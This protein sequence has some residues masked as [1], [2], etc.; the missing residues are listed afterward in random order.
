MNNNDLLACIKRWHDCAPR[1]KSDREAMIQIE[2]I[3]AALAAREPVTAERAEMLM[4]Y[5]DL[6]QEGRDKAKKY[7][8]DWI[9]KGWLEIANKIR[10]LILGGRG[11]AVTGDW[12]PSPDNINALPDPLKKY[13]HDL[14]TNCDPARLVQENT[15]L[16]DTIHAMESAQKELDEE[17]EAALAEKGGAVTEEFIEKWVKEF[18]F[19]EWCN[20]DYPTREHLKS[21]IG[22]MLREAGVAGKEKT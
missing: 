7:S 12:I 4:F 20:A 3:L 8:N 6:T 5:D 10:A 15:C 14:E 22:T 9:W 18:F 21:R 1:R 16:W 2:A 19:A 17:R 13:I 11:G